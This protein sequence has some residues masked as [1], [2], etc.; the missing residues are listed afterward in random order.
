MAPELILGAK[1]GFAIDF[2]A[3]GVMLYEMLAGRVSLRILRWI[4]A[5]FGL[6][7]LGHG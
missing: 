1:Y 4:I 2:W 5:H 3:V 6:D 7:S